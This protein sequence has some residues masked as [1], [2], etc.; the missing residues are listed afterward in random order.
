MIVERGGN[1]VL[2]INDVVMTNAIEFLSRHASLNVGRDHVQHLGGQTAGNTHFFYFFRGLNR[3]SHG[4][5][6]FLAL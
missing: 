1:G 5:E 3:Y 6:W 4:R 2:G